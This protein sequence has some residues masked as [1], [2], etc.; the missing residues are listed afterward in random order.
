MAMH[1]GVFLGRGYARGQHKKRRRKRGKIRAMIF[2]SF[3]KHATQSEHSLAVLH[4][5]DEERRVLVA[6]PAIPAHV[7]TTIPKAGDDGDEDEDQDGRRDDAGNECAKCENWG[8]NRIN[9]LDSDERYAWT[10]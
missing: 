5:G 4:T 9:E 10:A 8:V 6:A 2:F 3:R 7:V 1:G